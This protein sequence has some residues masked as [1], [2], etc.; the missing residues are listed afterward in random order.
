MVSYLNTNYEQM[1]SARYIVFLPLLLFSCLSNKPDE[2]QMALES[3]RS[4]SIW[5]EKKPVRG[6]EQEQRKVAL[7]MIDQQIEE[8]RAEL[9]DAKVVRLGDEIKITFNSQILFDVDS[10]IVDE[11]SASVLKDLSRVL[12]KYQGTLIEV[13]GHTDNTGDE[14]YNENLSKRRAAAVARYSIRQGVNPLR[15]RINGYGESMPVASNK[16]EEGRSMNRRV[17]IS[18]KGNQFANKAIANAYSKVK[19]SACF[20]F[21]D[22]YQNYVCRQLCESWTR[23]PKASI[24]FQKD[25]LKDKN[26]PEEFFVQA[27]KHKNESLASDRFDLG[28]NPSDVRHNPSGISRDETGFYS[29]DGSDKRMRRQLGEALEESNGVIMH[30]RVRDEDCNE[31]INA[32]VTVRRSDTGERVAEAQ[33]DPLTGRYSVLLEKGYQYA[34][35]IE[36]KGYFPKE[37]AVRIPDRGG[38][39]VLREEF[40]LKPLKKGLK[41]ELKNVFFEQSRSILL[42]ASYKELI[43]IGELLREN[44]TVVIELHGHTDGIGDPELNMALSRD[45]VKTIRDFLVKEGIN[46]GRIQMK[47]FGGDRPIASNETEETRR[48]NRRVEFVIIN[49]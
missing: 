45:R 29:Y 11:S 14:T 48:L 35:S 49:H 8:L 1:K 34:V 12:N 44:P 23:L 16:S 46:P 13:S 10:D 4:D 36:T 7:D 30:G 32:K 6:P 43:E 33:A 9:K 15:F 37:E 21:Y 2:P 3:E 18:I 17:E 39:T 42:E 41:M 27:G 24:G 22:E 5:Q 31:P 25:L 20:C 40:S 47:A 26:Q 38:Y 28:W 19:D